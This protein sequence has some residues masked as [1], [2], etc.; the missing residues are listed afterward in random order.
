VS[1]DDDRL[2]AAI[3]K[4][5]VTALSSRDYAVRTRKVELPLVLDTSAVP[6][7]LCLYRSPL[8]QTIKN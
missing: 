6:C 3:E 2:T 1:T 5:V 8:P 7:E 4:R